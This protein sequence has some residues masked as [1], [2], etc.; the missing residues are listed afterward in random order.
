M[1]TATLVRCHQIC[2]RSKP[3]RSTVIFRETRVSG[4]GGGES[5]TKPEGELFVINS[6]ALHPTPHT[7]T[8]NAR[9]DD[10]VIIARQRRI[11]HASQ[12]FSATT[13]VDLGEH[14]RDGEPH[15]SVHPLG[16]WMD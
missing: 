6:H 2:M 12:F 5:E 10:R 16:L 1:V 11:Q 9:S 3:E 8:R 7:R 15:A 14:S 4:V 13:S